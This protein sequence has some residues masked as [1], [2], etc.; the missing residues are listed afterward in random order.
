MPVFWF[1]ILLGVVALWFLLSFAYK[2]IGRF[3][4][5]IFKDS[6]HAMTSDDPKDIAMNEY[7]KNK[8]ND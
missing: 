4:K 8:R 5:R 2:G 6:Y 3:F 1:L 7:Y